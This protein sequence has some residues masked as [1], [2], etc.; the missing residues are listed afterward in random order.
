MC[1]NKHRPCAIQYTIQADSSATMQLYDIAMHL[2]KNSLQMSSLLRSRIHL[3][4]LEEGWGRVI[5]QR[6]RGGVNVA[7]RNVH[8][9]FFYNWYVYINQ[10]QLWFRFGST[11]FIKAS[12]GRIHQGS[13]GG[14]HRHPDRIILP[15]GM[16][17][18][19]HG[20]Y[21]HPD[22]TQHETKNFTYLNQTTITNYTRKRDA[23]V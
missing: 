4:H 18:V 6:K 16:A 7:W 11:N 2:A 20:E 21:R 15:L 17:G 1:N 3:T 8:H 22:C 14:K 19:G 23:S 9:L 13:G 10:G 12:T 5:G